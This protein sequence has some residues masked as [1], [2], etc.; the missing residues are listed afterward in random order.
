M[1]QNTMKAFIYYGPGDGR[2][3]DVPVPQILEGDDIIVKVVLSTICG[4]DIHILGGHVPIVR[5]KIIIGHEF[6][7]EVVE[8]GPRV[9]NLK[10]GDRVVVD[11]LSHCGVCHQCRQGHYAFC[12]NGACFGFTKDDGCQAEYCRVP[13]ANSCAYKIPDELDNEDVLFVG[14]ILSTGYHAAKQSNIQ[15]GDTVVVFGAGPVGMCAMLSSRLFTPLQIIAVDIN[16][17]RLD[18]CLKEGLADVILN[19]CEDNVSA[20]VWELTRGRGAD[21]SIEASGFGPAFDLALEAVKP[22]GNVSMIGMNPEPHILNMPLV[23]LKNINLST[24]WLSTTNIPRLIDLIQA[25]KINTKFLMTHRSP[26]NDILQGY[27][28]F[29]NK[30]DGCLKW[31]VTSY[32]G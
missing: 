22:Y 12:E 31:I 15:P 6:V 27:D 19:P 13:Y 16:P 11:C 25:G 30:K 24:G 18:I 1:E 9:K 7:G 20:K 28:I 10:P 17:T 5:D 14:D 21:A 32:E 29:G 8:A 23:S 2:L 3:E 26:L 4:S